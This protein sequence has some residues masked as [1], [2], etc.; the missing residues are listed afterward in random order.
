[1]DKTTDL[2]VGLYLKLAEVYREALV[3]GLQKDQTV[4]SIAYSSDGEIKKKYDALF[5]KYGILTFGTTSPVIVDNKLIGVTVDIKLVDADSRESEVISCFHE[6][7]EGAP[8]GATITMATKYNY[9]ETFRI[10]LSD[11]HADNVEKYRG[12][13][14]AKLKDLEG[15]KAIAPKDSIAPAP[16]KKN[17]EVPMVNTAPVVVNT[18]VIDTKKETMDETLKRLTGKD[19]SKTETPII[20]TETLAPVIEST[21]TLV[22]ETNSDDFLRSINEG[23]KVPIIKAADKEKAIKE[24]DAAYLAV[25]D[26]IYIHED[27]AKIGINI[28]EVLKLR[29]VRKS[30]AKFREYIIEHRLF[31]RDAMLE[32]MAND[33]KLSIEELLV[34]VGAKVPAKEKTVDNYKEQ[35]PNPKYHPDVADETPLVAATGPTDVPK[36]AKIN[37]DA[38]IEI[39]PLVEGPL[40]LNRGIAGFSSCFNQLRV[41][42]IGENEIKFALG[43]S[44]LSEK[45]N[46]EQ[47]GIV[48]TFL[49]TAPDVDIK[50]MVDFCK[51]HIKE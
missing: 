38:N 50:A 48:M 41:I 49:S 20:K 2:P 29:N 13:A 32:K 26:K 25:A 9:V 16:E 39:P 6:K 33:C 31:G 8:F 44:D 30:N 3:Q 46:V 17:E 7:W 5:C 11:D 40:G 37:A 12:E 18:D 4:G 14:T 19:P 47:Q 51:N 42:G 36:G 27:Y 45:Y 34:K 24:L 23:W 10:P 15:K 35:V 28:D 22:A 1:M 21:T 43:E